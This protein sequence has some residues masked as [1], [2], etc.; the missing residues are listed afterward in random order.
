PQYARPFAVPA[1]GNVSNMVDFVPLGQ[2]LTPMLRTVSYRRP[3]GSTKVIV[4]GDDFRGFERM[5]GSAL[6]KQTHLVDVTGELR[7]DLTSE[8]MP[9]GVMAGQSAQLAAAYLK[10]HSADELILVR[11]DSST[12]YQVAEV[13]ECALG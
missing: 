8:P 12:P 4:I 7:A 13:G 3:A 1:D 10:T 5:I 6:P 2:D 11:I 9:E